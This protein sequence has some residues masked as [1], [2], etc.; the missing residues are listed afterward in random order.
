M[1][2]G[3]GGTR[4]FDPMDSVM[5]DE[6]CFFVKK[7]GQR[8]YLG[9]GKELPVHKVE[10]KS[11]IK[12]VMFLA[13]VG[14]PRRDTVNNRN[15]DGKIGIFPFTTRVRAQR[16]SRNRAAGTMETKI[17]EVTKAVYKEKML[18]EVFPAIKAMWPVWVP[19]MG[20]TSGS[21]TSRPTAPTPT[22]WTWVFSTPSSPSKIGLR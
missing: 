18:T 9:S 12:K 1:L 20:G 15:F 7:N 14:R 13:V 22:S 8:Y 19:R 21:A 16:S 5:V 11:H 2:E 10:H 4:V 3:H 17:M 6:N